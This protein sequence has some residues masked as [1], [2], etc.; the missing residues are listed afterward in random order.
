VS[1][2]CGRQ[3]AVREEGI[4]VSGCRVS[5]WHS[6][7]YRLTDGRVDSWT[8]SQDRGGSGLGVSRKASSGWSTGITFQAVGESS[9]AIGYC[10]PGGQGTCQD[11]RMQLCIVLL[12]IATLRPCCVGIGG[13]NVS[14]GNCVAGPSAAEVLSET[15]DRPAA[16]SKKGPREK[17][18]V[19]RC[20]QHNSGGSDQ[21]ECGTAGLCS[22]ASTLLQC[23][24]SIAVLHQS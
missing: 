22:V 4:R 19:L 17:A 24:L 3:A 10:I 2:R 7:L 18:T 12:P 14:Q 1:T 21:T 15:P 16:R 11:V 5:G 8:D 13:S 20:Y 23:H 6:T 9:V